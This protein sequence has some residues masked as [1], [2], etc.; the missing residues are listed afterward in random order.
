M[1][2]RLQNPQ[3]H[4]GHCQ[5]NYFYRDMSGSKSFYCLQQHDSKTIRMMRCSSDW[6]P[7]HGCYPERVEDMT[8]EFEKPDGDSR[9]E[10]LAREWIKEHEAKA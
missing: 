7:S 4:T 2:F 6:E 5:I 3:T 9:L 1:K 8:L 10:V